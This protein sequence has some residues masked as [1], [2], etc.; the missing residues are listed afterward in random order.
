MKD[1]IYVLDAYGLIYRSYFAFISRP[2]TNSKGENVSAIFGFFKSL[3]SIF[4]EYNP[5]LFVTALDSV[6][7]TFRHEMYKEYKATRDKTPDDLHAQIDKIEEILKTFKL[8]TVR[9][10]GFEA[11]DVI[12]SIAA[13]AEKEDR[14]CVI[15]SGDKDLMQ[16]VSKTTTMLKPGKIKAWEG[17]DAEN[18]K[19]EWGVYPA[20]ML[21]LLSLIGDSADNV[22]GIKG[23][24]PKT[25]VKLLEEYKT[26]DGIYSNTKNLKGALKTKIEEGKESAYFSKELIRLRFDVP[27][28]KDLNAYSTSQMDYEAA[29]R[30]FISEELPN[31]A[32]LYSEKIIAE[33]ALSKHEKNETSS[34]ENLKQETGLFENS[35]QTSPE[36]LPQE[37][38]TGEEIS[39][40]QNKGD[41]KLVDEAEELFKIVDE[42]LKQGL[43]AYD[44]ET[45]SEDPLNAEVCGFSIAL[46]EGV[47]YYFPLKAPCPELGEEAPKLIA[48]KDAKKA[49]TKLFDSKMTLI[50]HN[51]KFDI[52][53]ALSSKL[54]NCISANLFDTMVAA[55]LLD[56]TRSSYGM[57]KL[58]ESILNVKTIRFKEVVKDR[59]NFSD[60]PLKEACPY[61]AEDADITFRFYKKFL[62]LLK[63]NNL[64]KL[65][66]DLEMPITKLLTEMEI[67]GIFLKGEELTAYS[68]ELGIEL[69]ECEKD[70]Y[71]LVGHEF[72]IASPKQL[73]EVLFE[74]RKLPTSKKTKTGY[75]TDTSVLE[76]LAS[77]DPVPA[78]I[79]DY[80]ALAKLKSTYTDTLPK[81][82]DKNGRIHTS[83]IQTGTATGRL[84]SR[85]PNLQNIPIR[86][87]EGRKIR[88]AFQAEKGRVLISADY[89][90]IELVILAHLSK[91]QNLVE[92]FNKGIDVHAKTASLIFAVDIKDVT[93]DMRRIAKTIN[94]GVMYGMSAFRLA[95]SLRIPRKR[96]DE[97]IKAYFATYSGVSGFMAKVCQEAEQ[98]GYVETIMGR[99]RYLPAINSKNKVEKA[100]AERI[101]VNTPIQG[102][103]ADI[104]KLAMLEVDKALKKQKLDASILLQVHDELIIEAAETE[105]EKV[106]SLV[107]EK[108]EGVIKLSVPLR[109]SIE[110]GMSWGEFH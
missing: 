86:G 88:E 81:M 80:R 46:K 22:P 85:D 59:Q 49:V 30:L 93:Q 54:A 25:A 44:C 29:A 35:E 19:E 87:N 36:M 100:G 31:I 2:L 37:L 74:E 40:P 43:A 7:P 57:D 77:E 102:T 67:K 84:S 60:V 63:K 50:M 68:K 92:A 69:E 83:F 101:A 90:Q 89:S 3:H 79:L 108:M 52:Q 34:K 104:V 8:P 48:F 96:A 41:Y 66:F 28:E 1:T 103:A 17:F 82:T 5:K 6:T 38:G 9:C 47:A 10:N 27:V 16:L 107:K 70:I 45:T 13:L 71:R 12:A 61:A 73:Q 62:P 42:A 23:V 109:V 65:F 75:S 76:N 78:K 53:A 106:M 32:K 91:D 98:R 11:D 95:S 4:T 64:E 18:V 99:R 97:F 39:L 110:S 72:N 26:L 33:K 14:E 58:A 15:I 105:R 51:G 56:P 21:D 24:G 55:W 20:G 94:F